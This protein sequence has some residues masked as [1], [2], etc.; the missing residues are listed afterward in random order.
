MTATS[1]PSPEMTIAVAGTEANRNDPGDVV[2]A[3]AFTVYETIADLA[4]SV[5]LDATYEVVPRPGHVR[6]NR[7]D[8][9]VLTNPGLLPFLAQVMEAD[10]ALA[11]GT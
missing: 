11:L 3:E 2:S 5:G 1:P 7:P 4:R 6:L 8:L 9:I 10:P